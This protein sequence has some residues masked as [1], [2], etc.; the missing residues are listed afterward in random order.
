[1]EVSDIDKLWKS[2]CTVVEMLKDRKYDVPDDYTIDSE[3]FCQWV[4]T[5]ASIARTLMTFTISGISIFWRESLGTDDIKDI[6]EKLKENNVTRSIVIYNNKI[7]PYAA[8]AIRSLKVQKIIIET[9]WEKELQYNVSRHEDVARHI[10][11]SME[12]KKQVFEDYHVDATTMLKISVTDPVCRY[13]GA[14]KGQLIKIVRQS[15]ATPDVI[16]NGEKKVLYDITYKL[17]S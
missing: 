10:I 15:D 16:V 11:C 17:V 7:T 12:T 4:G 14:T 13:Y 3:K 6:L 1:M 8:T 9:F 2:W 5:D